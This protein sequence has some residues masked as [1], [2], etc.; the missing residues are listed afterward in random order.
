MYKKIL[1][2][3]MFIST[4]I[5]AS[6]VSQEQLKEFKSEQ[7]KN[8]SKF[9]KIKEE[10]LKELAQEKHNVELEKA[11]SDLITAA[12]VGVGTPVVYFVLGYLTIHSELPG[13]LYEKFGLNFT[14]ILGEG[15]THT[16]I[17]IG[18]GYAAY[19]AKSGF[20]HLINSDYLNSEDTVITNN[21]V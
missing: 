3:G 13:I 7:E 9:E 15:L 5:V 1:V 18:E 8:Y 19:K 12:L 17:G 4:V 16:I 21:N 6:N 11:K 2:I 20:K 14:Y 10:K